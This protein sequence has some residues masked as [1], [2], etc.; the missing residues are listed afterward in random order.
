MPSN[1]PVAGKRNVLITSALIYVNNVPHLGNIV[2]SVLSADVFARYCRLRDYETLHI[3]GTD[4]YGTATETKALAENKTPQQICDEYH[5]IHAD[6]YRWFNIH[7]DEFGRTTND[8]QTPL[9]QDIFTKLE[10]N[11]YLFQETVEQLYCPPCD[12]FLA[13][14]FV[15]G[16]CPYCTYEDARGDQCDKCGKLINAI[17]LKQPKC[18]LCKSTPIVRDSKHF[19]FDLTKITEPLKEWFDDT[20]SRSAPPPKPLQGSTAAGD[21]SVEPTSPT[22]NS[23]N[24][25]TLD[26]SVVEESNSAVEYKKHL[27]SRSDTHWTNTAKSITESWFRDG[28]KPRCI[29][30]D[31]KWGTKVPF[32]GCENKVFYVW[33]DAPIGYLSITAKHTSDWE[34]WWKGEEAQRQVELYQFMAKDNVP[35]HSI[36]FP[37]T[38]LGTDEPWVKVKGLIASDYLN[39]ENTKFSKSRG[40]GVFG[41]DV[42]E[43]GIPADVW[44]FYLMFIRPEGQDSSFCWDDFRE[45]TNGE[46]LNNLG[47]FINRAVSFVDKNFEG[48][49]STYQPNEEDEKYLNEVGQNLIAYEER[50][51]RVHLRDGL[52]PIL[53]ISRLGN[54]LI[55]AN[56]PWVLVKGSEDD[57]SRA[58]SVMHLAL[59]TVAL[60]SLMLAPYM[61][62][63]SKQIKEQLNFDCEHLIEMTS[64]MPLLLPVGHQIGKPVLLFK[65]IESDQTKALKERFS[66]A[67]KKEPKKK[68]DSKQKKKETDN[69][70]QK[71]SGSQSKSNSHQAKPTNSAI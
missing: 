9:A 3:G 28:L 51:E 25:L 40:S 36:M 52:K 65:R 55:Q 22:N 6:I 1:G 12:R 29:T 68:K 56:K 61:P 31:L 21:G 59:N 35:F 43:T 53:S 4:E 32:A 27:L 8:L 5:V 70:E 15:E 54:Q 62:E 37:A 47:N 63:V 14:R 26:Q 66:G 13:D 30:R 57:R 24:G 33:F 67:V 19:F 58:E 71:E 46:L 60:L 11:H 2:G 45:K 64:T 16:V 10:K 17:D 20:V 7:F 34:K 41:N 44:R 38:L 39:Y 23:E 42:Q 49:V 50:L 18:K 48:K 69:Q